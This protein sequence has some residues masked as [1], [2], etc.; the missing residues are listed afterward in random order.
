MWKSRAE[1]SAGDAGARLSRLEV[2]LAD[3]A[4]SLARF[5]GRHTP[6]QWGAKVGNLERGISTLQQR[7]PADKARTFHEHG[8]HSVTAVTG[9]SDDFDTAIA[10]SSL[11]RGKSAA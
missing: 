6:R 5:L 10:A 11:V 4:K 3:L 7:N 1:E 2:T 9:N 8:K